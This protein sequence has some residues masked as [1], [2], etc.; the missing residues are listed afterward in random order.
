MNLRKHLE[1]LSNDTWERLR[2]SRSLDI[3]FGEETITDLVL[4]ELKRKHSPRSY[5]AQ[6]PVVKE[7]TQGTD[8]EWWVGSDRIG[9]IR[10]AVQAKRLNKDMRYGAITH[11]VNGTQQ[12]KLLENY[13][14]ANR[15]VPIY[16]FYN[17]S[18]T[19]ITSKAWNCKLPFEKQQLACTV[20][21]LATAKSAV[22]NRG[23]KSF[24][25][26]HSASSTIP[27]RCLIACPKILRVYFSNSTRSD[28]SL[29][30]PLSDDNVVIHKKLPQELI[31]ARDSGRIQ[32]FSKDFYSD[33]V[34]RPRRIL[35]LESDE[36]EEKI[37][38][39]C[40]DQDDA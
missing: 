2:D 8:W 7:K 1:E 5:I 22:K 18:K 4:L 30:H 20:A 34:E 23:K 38:I 11:K 32:K 33:N 25:S 40:D 37:D 13:A 3:R 19:G 14:I 6:T 36:N 39:N 10:Y 24:A 21:S 9:W 26:V 31:Q 16:C 27:W 15:A 17:Y 29:L 12:V 28:S 35:V